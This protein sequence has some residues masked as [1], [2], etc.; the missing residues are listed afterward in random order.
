M[1]A[2]SAV[3]TSFA[4]SAQIKALP[5]VMRPDN[6][7]VD[8]NELYVV[9]GAVITVYSLKDSST[10]RKF[11]KIGEGPGELK[12]LPGNYY[13]KI[14][15]FPDHIQV[16]SIDKLACFTK[17]GEF[18]KEKRKKVLNVRQTEPVGKNFVV[19]K[20]ITGEDGLQYTAV[21]LC[22]SEVE[23]IK[24]LYRQRYIQQGEAP[25]IK[26]DMIMDFVNFKVCDDKIFIEKSPKGFVIDVLD[27]NGKKLYEINK[28]YEI[29]NVTDAHEKEFIERFKEDPM[30]KQGIKSVG[31]W[32][33]FKNMIRMVFPDTF[34]AIQGLELSDK[35]LYIQTFKVKDNRSE[36][37]IMDLKGNIIK[38]VYLP[39]FDNTPVMAKMLDA[40]LHAIHN[41]KLY[42]LIENLDE[43]VWELHIE[44]IK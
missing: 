40:K 39:R 15:V 11:G 14:V 33:K 6:I 36:Y 35:K 41:G 22:N 16:E 18:L 5:E 26:M 30:V 1:L 3:V 21:L 31:D 8:G 43:E 9:E 34:P 17:K 38:K 20:R 23:V 29:M 12:V 28:K 27:G 24:E 42:Y 19:K 4:F 44:E 25:P 10:I 13:N 2:V 37:V 32:A 7:A